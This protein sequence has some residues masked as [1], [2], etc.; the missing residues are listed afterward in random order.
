[1]VRGSAV[2]SGDHGLIPQRVHTK[3]YRDHVQMYFLPSSLVLSMDG[4]EEDK[5]SDRY[6]CK[7][8]L[9]YRLHQ[10]MVLKSCYPSFLE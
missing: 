6:L 10:N 2:L 4:K 9:E 5:G 3:D 7:G 1:V 8:L